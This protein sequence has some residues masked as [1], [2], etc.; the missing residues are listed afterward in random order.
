MDQETAHSLLEEAVTGKAA[1]GKISPGKPAAPKAPPEQPRKTPGRIRRRCMLGAVLLVFLLGLGTGLAVLRLSQGPLRIDGMSERVAA[2]LAS[3]IGSGWRV[4]LKD[5]SLELDSENSLALRVAGLAV[6]NPEG[7]LVVSAPLA[8]VSIDTWGL[9]KFSVQPR[10]IEFRDLRMTALVHGDGSIAFAASS[11]AD[12]AAVK[13]HTLPSVDP[14]RGTV[15]PVSAAVASIFGVVLDSAGVVGALDRARITNGRLTLIDDQAR[16]RA[17]FERVN[18]LFRRDATRDARIFELRIDGPHGEWRFGGDVHEEGGGRRAGTITLDDLPVTDMLL[19]G[20]LSKLPVETDLKLSASADVAINAGRIEAMKVGLHSG[21]GN[22]LIEEKDFNPV[23]IETLA[24]AASWDEASRA[25]RLDSL[26]YSGAGNTVRLEGAWAQ[27]APG[28]DSMWTFGFSGSNAILRGATPADPPVK[29]AALKG[30]LTGREG[31]ISIDD[32][33]MRGE[34]LNGTITGTIGTRRDDDGITLRI[35]ADHTDGRLALRLWPEHIAPAV[36]YYLVDYLVGGQVDATD[37]VVD[38]SG[39]EMASAIQGAPL[40][41]QSLHIDLAV[42][43]A[44]LTVSRDAPPLSHAR[45]KG[46]ITGRSTTI[47]GA[48]ADLRMADNRTLG[49]SDG[50]FTIRDPQPD[51]VP[52]QIGFRLG[53]GADAVAALLQTKMLKGLT[54]TDIDPATVKG[55]ADLRIDFPLNLKHVP[56]LADIPVSL[57]G[58]LS[59]LSVDRAFGKERFEQGRFA[60]NYDR[61]GFTMKGDGRVLGTPLTIDLKQPKPGAPGEALISLVLDETFRAKKG[62]PVAPQLSGPI[63]ARLTVPIGRPGPGK[64]PIRVEAD[65]T[66]AGIDGLLP[67]W[68]KAAGKPGKLGFTLA[69]T[70]GGGSDLRDIVLDAAPALAR[71]SA[72]ITAD[73]GFDRAELT[74]L[75]LS[76]GDDMRVS[77]DHGSG[78]YKVAV[79]GQVADARPFLKSLTGGE[80]KKSRDKDGKDVEA[81]IA[82]NILTGHNG[83]ALTNANLKL[84]LRDGDVRN[85]QI[86]GRFGSSPLSASIRPERGQP[87]LSLESTDSGATL[88]F[89]DVYK[90]MYGGKLDLSLY[91]NDGPQQGAVKVSNFVLRDEPALSRI[92]AS[93]PAAGDAVDARGRRV[94]AASD[95]G[96]DRMRAVF[97]RNGPRVSFSDAVISNAAMGFTMGGWLDTAKERTQ[98]D[99][100]FVPLYALNNVVAH[101]PI[102]GPLLAGDRNEGLFGVNFAVSGSITK[103]TVNVNPLSAVAPGFL[104]QLFGA[105]GGAGA[106]GPSANGLPER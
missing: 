29:V 23:T 24:A 100:T 10:S 69:E 44:A 45:L 46:V 36:R 81:D 15:S 105:G 58:A 92:M 85:A 34:K 22:L 74:S 50:S 104:R 17:V 14:A 33:S 3:S 39:A 80:P 84:S 98:I 51:K 62:Y 86:K 30:Q 66:K 60:L 32:F 76:P 31:G 21:A 49:I 48:S 77:V 89:F 8:V 68:S 91:L 42:S 52:A 82:L 54:G 65:L 73:G 18:G 63:P 4:D 79:K 67:G 70:A 71:G 27:S 94:A 103:P 106:A 37:I 5:S 93:S 2:S 40:P 6:F 9:L 56:D 43:D 101:V 25:L 12:A 53:G 83:E 41:D 28:S 13:P 75:K 95:V 26:D 102:V 20:G 97:T 99:G 64:A 96:F 38:L 57:N 55:R 7:A 11:P 47:G 19:L 72:A 88:R 87:L 1:T 78:V 90:R 59:D 16:E 61:S 35:K